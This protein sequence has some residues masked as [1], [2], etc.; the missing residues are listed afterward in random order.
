V[1]SSQ[2]ATNTVVLDSQ[3]NGGIPMKNRG[4]HLLFCLLVFAAAMTLACGSS[5][6]PFRTLQSVTI[7]PATADAQDYPDGQVPFAATGFYNL[8]PTKVVPLTATWGACMQQTPTTA[9]SVSASGAAQCATGA[10]GTYTV[11]A[12]DTVP[13]A[14]GTASCNVVNA[15]GGGCERVTG[16]AELICP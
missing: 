4:P 15:C 1:C 6:T 13:P 10:S 11:W 5:S 16:T 3:G 9:V 2:Q 12:F 8:S 14:P 7:S